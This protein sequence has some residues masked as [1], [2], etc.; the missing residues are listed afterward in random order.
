MN[1]CKLR[2]LESQIESLVA[3]AKPLELPTRHILISKKERWRAQFTSC[4]KAYATRLLPHWW[5]Q[6]YN[7]VLLGAR[8]DHRLWKLDKKPSVPLPACE[9]L[10]PITLLELPMKAVIEWRASNVLFVFK[11]VR[12]PADAQGKQR[13]FHVALYPRATLSAFCEHYPDLEQRLNDNQIAAT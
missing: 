7:K 4:L 2:L 6:Q 5:G 1:R 12:N 3:V 8:L 9:T 13:A 11:V 10:T